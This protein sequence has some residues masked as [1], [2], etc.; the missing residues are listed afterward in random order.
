MLN[1]VRG[2]D[3][4]LPG[5]WETRTGRLEVLHDVSDLWHDDPHGP[6]RHLVKSL[7]P[8]KVAEKIEG[9]MMEGPKHREH[10]T[11]C[12]LAL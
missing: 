11:G 4:R 8:E 3:G 2:L 12:N 1:A 7:A 9:L 6:H 5:V 10:K